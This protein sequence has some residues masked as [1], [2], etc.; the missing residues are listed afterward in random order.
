MLNTGA[1]FIRFWGLSKKED[2]VIIN[3]NAEEGGGE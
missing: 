1:S 2:D 3:Y